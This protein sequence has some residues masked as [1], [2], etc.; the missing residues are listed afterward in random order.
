MPQAA[1]DA[2]RPDLV[3]PLAAIRELLLLLVEKK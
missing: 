3:M 1:I 2:S